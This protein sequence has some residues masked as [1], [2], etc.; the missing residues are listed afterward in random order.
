MEYKPSLT[1]TLDELKADIERLDKQIKAD[2]K[3]RGLPPD[4]PEDF[5]PIAMAWTLYERCEPLHKFAIKYAQL[6]DQADEILSLSDEQIEWARSFRKYT[7]LITKVKGSIGIRV[8]GGSLGGL[9]KAIESHN[10]YESV[11]ELLRPMFTN[12]EFLRGEYCPP[13][14]HQYVYLF[15]ASKEENDRF[16]EEVYA[17]YERL[18]DE[19]YFEAEFKKLTEHYD[20]IK[21]LY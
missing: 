16:S 3:A 12:L 10:E 8:L 21:H 15:D 20:S 2:R 5:V 18:Q 1:M 14:L 9:I 11:I 4:P 13:R 7:D 19:E 17:E 6:C